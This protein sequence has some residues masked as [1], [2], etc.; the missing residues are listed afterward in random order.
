M[1]GSIANFLPLLQALNVRLHA[2]FLLHIS[3][4]DSVHRIKHS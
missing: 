1:A 3:R 4:L 2:S